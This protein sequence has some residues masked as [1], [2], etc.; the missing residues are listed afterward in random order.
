MLSWL[1]NYY[2]NILGRFELDNIVEKMHLDPVLLAFAFYC[3]TEIDWSSS[4]GPDDFSRTIL[5][6][7]PCGAT[8]LRDLRRSN[9]RWLM[10]VPRC[11]CWYL[12]S[13]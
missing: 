13:L 2:V 1:P 12:L 8:L 10:M 9:V 4:G 6:R 5:P 7:V 11:P 3:L